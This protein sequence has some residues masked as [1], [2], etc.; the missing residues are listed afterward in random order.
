MKI[1]VISGFL[2]AG[3][4]T[5][6]KTMS[7]KTGR[8]FCV[9]ENEY[10]QADIDKALLSDNSGLNI[11]ELTENCICCSG[12]QDF[13]SSVLTIANTIDPEYLIVE[14]T[15]VAKLSSIIKNLETICYERISLL[16]PL[17]IVDGYAIRN[18]KCDY[19]EIYEDQI[20]NAGC[21]IISK[22]ENADQEDLDCVKMQIKKLNREAAI[23][24]DHYSLQSSKWWKDILSCDI[25][26]KKIAVSDRDEELPENMTLT[27]V[28]LDGPPQLIAFL[29]MITF[30]VFG[31]ICRAKGF[32]PCGGQWLSFDIVDKIYSITGIDE[33]TEARAVFMG[34]DIFRAGIREM[35]NTDFRFAQAPGRV[36]PAARNLLKRYSN[37]KI[38]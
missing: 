24:T 22:M 13:A 12:K 17:V 28:S 21:V 27:G 11:W 34:Q 20:R 4:T 1:L 31:N 14:P 25:K 33:Q 35:L 7:K 9:F 10:A 15:G 19:R 18:G 3:K 26:G 38:R 5:F 2:G 16:S 29:E 6:I 32:L 37:R 8:D 36:D 30:G 23:L